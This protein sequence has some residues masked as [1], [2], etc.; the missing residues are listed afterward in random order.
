MTT[1]TTKRYRITDGDMK[2]IETLLNLHHNRL[3]A[4]GQTTAAVKTYALRLRLTSTRRRK[5]ETPA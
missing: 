3:A 1:E 4:A 2:L 5:S